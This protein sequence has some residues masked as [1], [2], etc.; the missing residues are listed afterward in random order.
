MYGP[1][2][3]PHYKNIGVNGKDNYVR[4]GGKGAGKEED[5]TQ[6]NV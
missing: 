1:K 2:L 3:W 6:G 4:R 5:P